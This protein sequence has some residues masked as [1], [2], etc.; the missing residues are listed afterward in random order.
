[1]AY[2]AFLPSQLSTQWSNFVL[3]RL[4]TL[5]NSDCT[6]FEAP[7]LTP[8][9]SVLRDVDNFLRISWARTIGNGWCSSYRMHEP[10]KLPCIFGC[11]G[12]RDLLPHYLNCP[13][14][15]GLTSEEL[16]CT[17]GPS[18]L[19]RLCIRDPSR[20]SFVMLAAI[21]G[22]YHYIKQGNRVL[23]DHTFQVAAQEWSL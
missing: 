4:G 10:V 21:Q 1:M 5:T 7:D 15:L 16:L 23:V 17:F 3:R 11:V 18:I 20:Q 14:L 19:H 8:T 2:R 9:F 22:I 12:E 13:I 6:Q